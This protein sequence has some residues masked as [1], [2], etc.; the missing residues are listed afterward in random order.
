MTHRSVQRD[1]TRACRCFV[2][3]FLRPDRLSTNARRLSI[4]LILSL[5]SLLPTADA[6]AAYHLLSS[7]SVCLTDHLLTSLS[8]LLSL[9]RPLLSHL[10]SCFLS[11]LLS[12]LCHPKSP[13]M[14]SFTVVLTGAWE[15]AGLRLTVQLGCSAE[16]VLS[17]ISRQRCACC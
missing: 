17:C 3:P 6:P 10:V 13:L 7:L 4:P 8:H 14:H 11:H 16:T 1:V 15:P 5:L 9:L 12:A 2:L